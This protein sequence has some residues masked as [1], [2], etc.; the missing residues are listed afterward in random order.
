[1]IAPLIESS[2]HVLMGLSPVSRMD[3][4]QPQFALTH[5]SAGELIKYHVHRRRRCGGL[6]IDIVYSC[7]REFM[8]LSKMTTIP[9]PSTVSTVLASRL[10]VSASKSCERESV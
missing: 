8:L 5:G 1:M 4:L 3:I 6:T 2:N 7:L 10:G 9:P